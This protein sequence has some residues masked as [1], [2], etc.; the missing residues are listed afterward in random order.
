M[1]PA[2]GWDLFAKPVEKLPRCLLAYRE[3]A[4]VR[5]PGHSTSGLWLDVMVLHS[6]VL[7][8]VVH[9]GMVRNICFVHSRWLTEINLA[10]TES[11]STVLTS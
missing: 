2:L 7:G 6:F 1:S 8:N 10:V 11:G 4:G 9:E 3:P 5:Y